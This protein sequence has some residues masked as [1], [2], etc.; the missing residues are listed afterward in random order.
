MIAKV[1]KYHGE[2]AVMINGVAYPPMTIIPNIKFRPEHVKKYAQAGMKLYFPCAVTNWG[3]PEGDYID[4]DGHPYHRLSGVEQFKLDAE[5]IFAQVPDA[6]I[7]LRLS[8]DPPNEWFD[9]HPDDLIRYNDGKTRPVVLEGYSR[10]DVIPGMYS[11]CSEN[12][13]NDAEKALKEYLEMFKDWKYA[14]RI[15]GFFLCAGGTMEWYYPEGNLLTDFE[16]GIYGD[17]SPAFRAEFGRILREKYGTVEKLRKAWNDPTATF[18]NPKIPDLEERRYTVIDGGIQ[19]AMLMA[20]SARRLVGKKIELNPKGDGF[21]GVFLDANTS[22]HV[23]DFF[24]AWH[25]GTANTI[26]RLAKVIKD[27]YPDMLVGAFY[28]AFGTTDYYQF[29]TA[30]GTVQILDSGYIDFLG[31]AGSYNNREP[32][33]YT[34]Q[35]EM[36]DSFRLRN[37]IYFIEADNRTHQVNDFYRNG[38]GVYNYRDTETTIKRDLGR[39]ICEDVQGWYGDFSCP[40]PDDPNSDWCEKE[41]FYDLL[42]RQGEI[43]KFAYSL[44]RTKKNEI[45]LLYDTESIHYVSQITDAMFCDIYRSTDLGRIGAPVDYY[46]HNDVA[47]DNMPDYKVYIA[48]NLFHLTDK[49]REAIKAK[50][51]KNHASVIWLYAPGFIN[52]DADTIMAEKNISSLV[53]MEVGSVEDTTYPWFKLTEEGAKLIKYA[54]RAQKYGYIDRHI[55]SGVWLGSIFPPPN[56]RPLPQAFANPGFYIEEGNAKVLGRFLVNGKA[57]FAVTEEDG[58]KSY[59]SAAPFLRSEILQ[60]IAEDAG[61]HL[62]VKT[63][64]HICANENFVMIH[65]GFSGK[66]TVYFKEKCSP[67]EVYEKKY[68]GKDVTE[69]EVDMDL[70]DTLMFSLRGEC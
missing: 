5:E 43:T 27:R 14:D 61:V 31:S 38:F 53:G 42:I 46:F 29:G 67:F 12:F 58:Y 17:F 47:R 21:R 6:Y 70:G 48:I 52:P 41:G 56:Y 39:V 45:A 35:R 51:R 60:S 13:R 7:M 11:L 55:N 49:E 36:Q 65:A 66:R 62:Y 34:A 57:A 3:F 64:D 50:A 2:P 4:D 30:E 68:Y 54:D 19:E 9:S 26:T 15:A 1:E 32:G 37:E 25:R 23:A 8:L 24:N 40:Y 33:G 20:E 69:I 28:G 18:E 63:D 16:Q 59:Y 44:D 10:R 22:Q